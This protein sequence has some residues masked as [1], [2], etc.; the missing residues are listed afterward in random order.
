MPA[1][2]S[3]EDI[4]RIWDELGPKYRLSVAYIAR[5]VRIDRGITP[6]PL[7]LATRFSLQG[8]GAAK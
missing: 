6:G 8:N 4:L 7:V 3:L 2:L 1:D 5:V